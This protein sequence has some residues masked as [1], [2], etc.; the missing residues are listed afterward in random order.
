MAQA[1]IFTRFERFW[2]WAQ[3]L[4]ITGL[5]G[6]GFEVHGSWHLLGFEQAAQL[7]RVLA[8]TLIGL[9]VLAIFWHFT[10]GAW[11][12]YLPTRDG[13][14]A[15]ARYYGYGIFRGESHPYRATRSAKHNPLQRLAYLFLKLAISPVTWVSG[16]LYLF[17]HDLH[18]VA[19]G[20]DLGL[21]AWVHTAAAFAM[22]VFVCGH[23][24]M[25]LLGHDKL[26]ELRH[27]RSMINGYGEV[28]E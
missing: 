15:V 19:P 23:V 2:H 25:T 5:F 22:A 26:F 13:L 16:L 14:G 17:Y 3:A 4:L 11:R 6:T 7:H 28:E 24:Y 27:V 8:W 1:L 20:L 21:V 9:W 10:T 18:A 12:H